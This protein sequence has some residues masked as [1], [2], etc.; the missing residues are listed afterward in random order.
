MR[1]S[2][3]VRGVV[4][5]LTLAGL[6]FEGCAARGAREKTPT[7]RPPI[8]YAAEVVKT[9]QS[10]PDGNSKG[11][12]STPPENPWAD[13]AREVLMQYCGRCH[14]GDLPTSVPKALAVFDLTKN[15]WYER[16]NSL[17]FE[18][19]LE[20]IRNDSKIADR[21]KRVVESFVRCAR[22]KACERVEE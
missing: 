22:D 4:T 12:P 1:T 21:D 20:R 8:P 14:R 15:P 16:L 3:L 10:D 11:E 5:V 19:M 17:H 13:P 18:G 2:I 7:P 6:D 9:L